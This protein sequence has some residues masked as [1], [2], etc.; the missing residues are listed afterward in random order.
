MQNFHNQAVQHFHKQTLQ[1]FHQQTLKIRMQIHGISI[2]IFVSEC[3]VVEHTYHDTH[4][5]IIHINFVETV[6]IYFGSIFLLYFL[7]KKC[8]LVAIW[9]CQ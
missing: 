8:I 9:S 7:I 4:I 3:R 6:Q 2:L 5:H 1:N